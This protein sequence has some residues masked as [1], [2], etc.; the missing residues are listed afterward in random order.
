MYKVGLKF[1]A[2][3]YINDFNSKD[4]RESILNNIRTAFNDTATYRILESKHN[5][6]V[7][8]IKYNEK[9]HCKTLLRI[10]FNDMDSI[11]AIYLFSI[12]ALQL[13]T[14]SIGNKEISS[15]DINKFLAQQN[16]N[17]ISICPYID[18]RLDADIINGITNVKMCNTEE[19]NCK[20]CIRRS[21]SYISSDLKRQR[22]HIES[23][24]EEYDNLFIV[25]TDYQQEVNSVYRYTRETDESIIDMRYT[26]DIDSNISEIN[27]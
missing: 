24:I 5:I 7:E 2:S 3:S 23:S 25:D 26:I 17:I 11:V 16:S 21:R 22:L 4:T 6:V 18:K 8:Y 20:T 13:E 10:V 15:T 1:S 9:Y 19:D 27:I 12:K 14:L